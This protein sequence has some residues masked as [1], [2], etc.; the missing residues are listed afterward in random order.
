MRLAIVAA[1]LLLAACASTPDAAPSGPP[2]LVEA[3]G[4]P[5]PPQARL[6]ADCITQAAERN[7]YDREANVLRFRCTGEPAQRFFDGLGA[8]SA[9]IGSEYDSADATWR[10]ST[11]IREN[12]SLT[13]FCRRTIHAQYDCTVVLNVGEFLSE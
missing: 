2:Q 7:S 12:P 3:P 4:Q 5:A 6:Y 1:A 10:F 8:W 13:D 11:T 9:R